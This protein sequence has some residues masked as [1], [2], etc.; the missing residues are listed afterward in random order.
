MP[1]KK[2]IKK[3]AR[4]G[5]KPPGRT[6]KVASRRNAR[7]KVAPAKVGMPRRAGRHE[8]AGRGTAAARTGREAPNDLEELLVRDLVGSG[9]VP[10]LNSG[11]LAQ[12][13]I[14]SLTASTRKLGYNLGFGV[15]RQIY[16][17]GGANIGMF[18]DVLE[19][20]GLGKVLYYPS[21]EH[22]V[23]TSMLDTKQIASLETGAHV[24]ESGVI[25]GYFSGYLNRMVRV[26]ET[27]CIFKNSNVCQF[28]ADAVQH[29]YHF[30]DRDPKLDVVISAIASGINRIDGTAKNLENRDYLLLPSLPLARTPLLDEAC[31]I[32]YLAGG[33]L[34]MIGG[35]EYKEAIGKIARYFDLE[36]A[37]VTESK[38]KRIIRLKYKDYN[39]LE[40]IVRLS[41]S[42]AMGY[43]AKASGSEPVARAS[44]GKNGTYLV[45]IRA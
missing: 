41:S 32:L 44:V 17:E 21:E 4:R 19:K 16:R 24:F 22:V 39:S 18:F 35:S 15:G 29:H 9:A 31:K 42:M 28:I 25:A 36:D 34:A 8:K 10:K 14:L 27:L 5:R 11:V 6:A 13:L 33:R 23:I 1:A 7:M 38:G 2:T 26:R 3:G 20:L 45:S 12:D 43:V 40:G 30:V 37:Q